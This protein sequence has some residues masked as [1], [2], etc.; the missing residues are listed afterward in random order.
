VG[1]ATVTGVTGST[2][3]LGQALGALSGDVIYLGDAPAWPPADDAASLSLA[4]RAGYSF[5]RTLVDPGGARGVPHYR[6]VDMLSDNRLSPGVIAT[7]K[8]AFAI[9]PGCTSATL[10]AAVLYRP[11][12]VA[13]ARERGWEAH[14]FVVATASTT[15]ALP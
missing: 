14:D 11:V 6:A 12:P 13:L 2:L 1:E 7:T 8:H 9:P 10:S 3:T 4:G 15:V 5:A